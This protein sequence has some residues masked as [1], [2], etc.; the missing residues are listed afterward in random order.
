MD[1]RDAQREQVGAFVQVQIAPQL[2]ISGHDL[3]IVIVDNLRLYFAYNFAMA[4]ERSGIEPPPPAF[5]GLSNPAKR[6]RIWPRAEIVAEAF[7][8]GER[9]S[10]VPEPLTWRSIAVYRSAAAN[11]YLIG[12]LALRRIDSSSLNPRPR[13]FSTGS[14]RP[15]F[16][17][18]WRSRR[19][20]P[21]RAGRDR[22]M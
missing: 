4:A 1:N 5:S 12:A 11:V 7:N 21:A 16:A 9:T 17:I 18:F 6:S 3:S 13:T 20:N 2:L 10:P 19:N 14:G 15:L 8:N 22:R